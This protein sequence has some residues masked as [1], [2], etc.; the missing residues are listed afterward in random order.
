MVFVAICIIEEV[1][2]CEV[3]DIMILAVSFLPVLCVGCTS[4]VFG[5]QSL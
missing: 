2:Y 5:G 4:L 1:K 3:L